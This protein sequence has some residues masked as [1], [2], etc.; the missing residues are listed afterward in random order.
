MPA[1]TEAD[2]V[3][4]STLVALLPPIG[5]TGVGENAAVTPLG[6]PDAVRLVAALKPLRLATVTVLVPLAPGFIVTVVGDAP[7]EK[8]GAGAVDETAK[9]RSSESS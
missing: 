5:V 6:K 2:A 1:G 9:T 4:V 3:S 7:N 8:S